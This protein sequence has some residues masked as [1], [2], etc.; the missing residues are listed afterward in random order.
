MWC[1]FCNIET[2][3]EKCPICGKSTSED[4]PIEV[5][6]CDNCMVPVIKQVTDTKRTR[7]QPVPAVDER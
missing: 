1:K 6:W 3:E 4:I 5:Y 2:N 7:E